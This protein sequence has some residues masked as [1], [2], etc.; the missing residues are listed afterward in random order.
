M[1]SKDSY[2]SLK[3]EDAGDLE[4]PAWWSDVHFASWNCLAVGDRVVSA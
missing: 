3:E 4:L 2:A 1:G